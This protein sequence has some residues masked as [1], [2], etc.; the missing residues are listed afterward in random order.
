MIH[1]IPINDFLWN[2]VSWFWC[3][4]VNLEQEAVTESLDKSYRNTEK[5][6][7]NK[8]SKETIRKKLIKAWDN[9]KKLEKTSKDISI[10]TEKN[11]KD[12]WN[13]ND[14]YKKSKWGIIRNIL[15]TIFNWKRIYLM[16]D[17]VWVQAQQ[18]WKKSSEPLKKS[19]NDDIWSWSKEC[20]VWTLIKQDW[21]EISNVATFCTWD[22]I[23]WFKNML[24]WI[25]IWIFGRLY[26]I[27]II[28]DWAVWIRN[29]RNKILCLK[30]ARWILDWFHVKD[31]ILKLM[32]VLD[33][34]E[35]SKRT[36]K[37]IE[38]LWMWQIDLAVD[39]I[40]ALPISKTNEEK[41]QQQKAKKKSC[42]KYLQNQREWIINY[43]EY[44]MKWHIVWSWFVEKLNDTLVKNRMVR[45]K[46]MR[47]SRKWWEAMMQLL[48]AKLNW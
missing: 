42:I 33:I 35:D 2:I 43:H 34:N 22:R 47:W 1:I 8:F 18:W 46:R 23:T 11:T 19:K 31:H 4:S 40:K 28:S 29:L 44:Q 14:S 3:V 30:N 6:M 39:R 12:P 24:E 21:E 17:W 48:T 10:I 41:N 15:W 16:I 9:A 37:I 32:I 5:Y 45:Q 38:L 27:T 25:L 13:Q 26:P 7:K 20:K 36:K